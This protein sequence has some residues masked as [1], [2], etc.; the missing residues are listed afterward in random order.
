MS[1]L[2]P[3]TLTCK[4][5]LVHV[6]VPIDRTKLSKGLQTDPKKVALRDA[7]FYASLGV[8]FKLHSVRSNAQ[9]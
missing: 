2:K 7:A 4:T 3:A 5:Y 1:F 8:E 9:E 6:L